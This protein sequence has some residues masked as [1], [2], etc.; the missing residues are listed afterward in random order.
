MLGDSPQS[1]V[2]NGLRETFLNLS[3]KVKQEYRINNNTWEDKILY[4]RNGETRA[5]PPGPHTPH[6]TTPPP[7]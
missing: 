4:I 5:P 2:K 1:T 7:I 6:P 3:E